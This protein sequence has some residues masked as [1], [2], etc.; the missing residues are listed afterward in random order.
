MKHS[1]FDGQGLVEY[2]LL[3][4]LVALAAVAALTLLGGNLSTFFNAAAGAV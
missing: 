2:S 4:I 3:V 1:S